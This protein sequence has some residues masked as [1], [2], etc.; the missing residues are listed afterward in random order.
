VR[1]REQ[2]EILLSATE[3]LRR[4]VEEWAPRADHSIAQSQDQFLSILRDY[5]ACAVLLITYM[6]ID[7]NAALRR[8]AL[9]L[10]GGNGRV[11][12]EAG[13]ARMPERVDNTTPP[14]DFAH[15][16]DTVIL[17]LVLRLSTPPK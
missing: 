6:R 5:V 14:F 12:I 15:L 8:D 3:T 7:N 17:P 16:R 4:Q 10:M 11:V 9:E 2:E 1:H 13:L